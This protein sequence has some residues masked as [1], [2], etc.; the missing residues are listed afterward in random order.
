MNWLSFLIQRRFWDIVTR[1]LDAGGEIDNRWIELP[2]SRIRSMTVSSQRHYMVALN[3]RS[4]RSFINTFDRLSHTVELGIPGSHLN[5]EN[6]NDQVNL[7]HLN[8]A[9]RSRITIGANGLGITY[10]HLDWTHPISENPFFEF[11]ES[12]YLNG[13]RV[14]YGKQSIHVTAQQIVVRWLYRPVALPTMI[15]VDKLDAIVTNN[16]H[17]IHASGIINHQWDWNQPIQSRSGPKQWRK[18]IRDLDVDLRS[19]F[20]AK[21]QPYVDQIPDF[22]T[23]YFDPFS[24]F[25]FFYSDKVRNWYYLYNEAAIDDG[26]TRGI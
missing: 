24:T 5:V 16:H 6:G 14:K 23:E 9:I 11:P 2:L 19:C 26:A 7:A 15:V 17:V 22:A 20:G 4:P 8:S 13:F 21:S 25:P 1:T 10:L 3:P 12:I 18:Q